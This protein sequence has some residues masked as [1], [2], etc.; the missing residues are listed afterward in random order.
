MSKPIDPTDEPG[1][2]AERR[3]TALWL[4]LNRPQ[5]LNSFDSRMVD[6]VIA[7]LH[8]ADDATAV[9]IT[10][11]GRAFCAGGFLENLAHPDEAE[12]R[13]LFR[14]TLNLFE[15]IR[16]CP[17]PVI[18]AING[19]AIGGGNE[20]VVACDFAIAVESAVLGQAGPRVG[21][22]AVLGGANL[23]ALA[24]GD[25]RAN[26]ISMLCRRYTA[27]QALEMGWINE[28]V[29]DD[30]LP[31][32]VDR[33][34]EELLGL[35]PRYLEITKISSNAWWN[36]LRETYVS[37]LGMLTQAIASPDMI[38]GATAF[39]EKRQPEFRGPPKP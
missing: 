24:V 13:A 4:R 21:S 33:W 38:E 32:G 18:A 19:P 11:T 20:L 26:E 27:Q 39:M 31:S 37:G 28:V 12:I 34:V 17:K 8:G 9:V 35:S 15:E 3:G 25:K 14:S 30:G 10:G 22:A 1:V 36:A 6:E 23:L 5:R 29:P 2:I 7:A 16:L